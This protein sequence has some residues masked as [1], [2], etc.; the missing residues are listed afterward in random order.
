MGWAGESL[1]LVDCGSTQGTFL[2]GQRLERRPAADEDGRVAGGP[3]LVS[4]QQRQRQRQRSAPHPLKGG[5]IIGIGEFRFVLLQQQL[6]QAPSKQRRRGGSTGGS[7]GGGGGG[8]SGGNVLSSGF[9]VNPALRRH[10]AAQLLSPH[11]QQ[12]Q[13]RRQVI[14]GGPPRV[15]GRR[16]AT[17]GTFRDRSEERR[18]ANPSHVEARNVQW[19]AV[20]CCLVLCCA[21]LWC[22]A[23]CLVM[24]RLASPHPR[25]A[26]TPARVGALYQ[27]CTD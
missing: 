2:N 19:R 25:T 21:V 10:V 26:H 3:K 14:G 1:A 23:P 4:D 11:E 20:A 5:D 12:Q 9:V 8:G 16:P 13:W 17:A 24:T 18:K 27:F 15:R 6:P 7:G 22:A